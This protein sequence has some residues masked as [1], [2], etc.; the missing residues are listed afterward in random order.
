MNRDQ[1]REAVFNR[2]NR[3]CVICDE[4]AVDAHHIIDRSLFDDGGYDVSNG[5]SLC[6]QH[7]IEAEMTLIS[8]EELRS[9]A[10]IVEIVLPEH[11]ELD[12]ESTEI[13]DHWGNMILPTG[14]RIKGEL[15]YQDNVQKVLAQ[16]GLLNKFL[17]YVKYQRTFHAPWS[18]NVSKDDRIHKSMFQ[19]TGRP[20]VC[21][22]KM[23]GEN[24]NLYPD[25][26]H[27]RSI[28]SKH[29]DSRSWVKAFHARIAHEIPDNWRLCGENLYAKHSIHYRHLKSYFYLF[30]IWN[31]F[32]RALSWGDTLTYAEI[33][34]I[35]TVPV[36]C[37]GTFSNAE[38]LKSTVQREFDQYCKSSRDEVEG[39][40][41]R[42]ADEIPYR[43][44]RHLTAKVV[45]KDHVQTHAFW[46]NGQIIPNELDV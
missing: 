27:A 22:I 41:I 14:M 12:L 40:V 21:T 46:M 4:P 28:E 8:C 32:N 2:D 43:D 30:S 6:E 7:H 15:F 44:F 36:F 5:V 37:T 29:H 45:R 13:Y 3:K 9:K 26:A 11:F 33:L 16:A 42:V 19:F 1:F 20:L 17:K 25:Y 23:D 24:F 10:N 35:Q 34:G 38:S 18:P 39:Y 31:E